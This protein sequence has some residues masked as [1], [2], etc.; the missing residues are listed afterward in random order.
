MALATGDPVPADLSVLTSG[1]EE[2][3]LD[4][5]LW[6]APTLVIFLRHLG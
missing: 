1:G 3:R 2:V 4:A 5:L 6:G